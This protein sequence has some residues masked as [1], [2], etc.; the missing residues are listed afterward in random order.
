[1]DSYTKY[2]K[3][4]WT[5]ATITKTLKE[6]LKIIKQHKNLNDKQ[7]KDLEAKANKAFKL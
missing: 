4:N 7:V 5:E 1:M 6:A 2:I 3:A